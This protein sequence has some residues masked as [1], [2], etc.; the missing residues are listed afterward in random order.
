MITEIDEDFPDPTP[1]PVEDNPSYKKKIW[2]GN[3]SGNEKGFNAD[4]YVR[5][6]LSY[7]DNDIGKGVE[8][9]GLDTVNWL[10]NAKDGYYYYRNKVGRRRSNYSAVYRFSDKFKKE[11][12]THT[13]T[14]FPILRSTYMKRQ[15]RQR[16]FPIIRVRGAILTIRYLCRRQRGG[17]S[18]KKA[19]RL[20]LAS[21]ITAGSLAAGVSAYGRFTDSVTVTNHISTGDINI[22]L[23]ELEK[24]ENKE[25]A[26]QDRKSFFQV[27]GSQKSP[28]L[29][30]VRNLLGKSEDYLY[31]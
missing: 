17:R 5:M 8:L 6:S 1:T 25:I 4:C 16:D 21:V 22:S 10:Y 9:L 11:S 15:F 27:T 3:F 28:G 14:V 18:L 13:E 31:G 26:Y 20:L 19:L 12:M 24:K 7:S 23:K 2:T 29:Q 30:I